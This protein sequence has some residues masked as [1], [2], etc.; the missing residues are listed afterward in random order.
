MKEY[1]ISIGA[2]IV[3]TSVISIILPN[4]KTGKFIKG[5][6][7]IIITLVILS[8]L[9]NVSFKVPNIGDFNTKLEYQESFLFYITENKING[10]E[11]DSEIILKNCGIKNAKVS[12]DYE[13]NE[14]FSHSIKK[15]KI[16][17]E[18]AVIISDGQHI[19]IIEEGV[20][21]L[22][23][24]LSVDKEDIKIDGNI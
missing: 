15:V 17:L 9:T 19:N 18:K 6:F 11:Y 4:G 22:S 10:L 20:N 12:I 3:I 5:L 13:V 24:Y 7:S 14:D 21:S 2:I 1:I 8:P 23:K 16:N